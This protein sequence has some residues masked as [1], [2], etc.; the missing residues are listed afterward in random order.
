MTSK[1]TRHFV[2][3][4]SIVLL[5]AISFSRAQAEPGI[6]TS[7]IVVGGVMDLEGRSKALGQGMKTGILAAFKNQKVKGK[8]VEYITLNDSYNPEKTGTATHELIDRDI[9]LMI[10]NVGTP[11]A[12]VSLPIL[13]DNKVPAVGFFTGAG[14][15]RP[16]KGKIIN[17]RAS[18]VQETAYVINAALDAGI[19]TNE[20]CAYVQNDAYGMAG[21]TGIKRALSN[22]AGTRSI[23]TLL[24]QIIAMPGE[25]PARNSIGPVGVYQRNTFSARDGYLSLKNW[26]K[27]SKT[28][29]RLV[30]TVG[31]YS[32]VAGFI[33]YANMKKEDWVYSAVSFTG[34][35][36]LQNAL[37]TYG[38]LEK[39][40]VTQTVPALD[41]SLPVVQQARKALAADF[42]Y[43]SLEGYLVGKMMLAI[44][45]SIPDKTIT[46]Q[47][48]VSAAKN[49][50]FNI[51]GMTFDFTNDNQASDLVTPT[52]LKDGG[53]HVANKKSLNRIFE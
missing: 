15:L 22:K 52:Y 27:E 12:K 37:A 48:F 25:N 32:S 26:E 3:I 34:A 2:F 5:S 8:N 19:K 46:R 14:L 6:S 11:T 39:V 28:S 10:G 44:M 13:A 31:S 1:H 9:F 45:N 30:L 18:Y 50:K 29:C 36:N 51:G 4:S 47:A 38:V 21:V 20:I 17:Y 35:T 53:Y 24:D 40:I 49:N 43:V 41:S 16:G 7:K 33:G 42:D 23:T